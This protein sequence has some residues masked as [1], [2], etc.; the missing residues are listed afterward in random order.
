MT[1][2]GSLDDRDALRAVALAGAD[3]VPLWHGDADL[4]GVDAVVLPG[5]FSYGDYLRGGAIARF[6]PV[7]GEI[8]P[9]AGHGH[10]GARHLQRLPGALRGAPA[11]RARWSA[12]PACASSAATRRSRSSP[13]PTALDRRVRRRPAD[14]DPGQARRGPV[15]RRRRRRST[16]SRRTAGSSSGTSAATRTAPSTTSPGS[17]TTAGNVVG[18]MPHPEHAIDALTGP[19]ADGLTMFTSVLQ[20]LV[21]A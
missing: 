19:S 1:F 21:A 9:R 2:P 16:S 15:R 7:V 12:T 18:L 8:V 20:A 11:A 6:S 17:P 4:Q 3:A 5:G 10:A 13:P 14:H